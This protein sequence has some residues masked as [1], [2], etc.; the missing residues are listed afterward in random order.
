MICF[1]HCKSPSF[2]SGVFLTTA[3]EEISMRVFE[4]KEAKSKRYQ[5]LQSAMD[6]E[7]KHHITAEEGQMASRNGAAGVITL[8]VPKDGQEALAT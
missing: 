4:E 5:E 8:W 7:K 3:I 6:G 1:I 2:H